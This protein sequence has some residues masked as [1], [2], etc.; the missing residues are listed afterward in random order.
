MLFT[1]NENGKG[2]GSQT[3]TKVDRT[4]R[5]HYRSANKLLGY[6]LLKYCRK[7]AI[8]ALQDNEDQPIYTCIMSLKSL[9]LI[10]MCDIAKTKTNINHYVK[11]NVEYTPAAI[12]SQICCLIQV[13]ELDDL[14]NWR[15]SL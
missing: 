11:S 1:A 6:L 13:A 2:I 7:C 12:T 9:G 14:L 4:T 10:S 8:Y 5:F 15:A 3:I